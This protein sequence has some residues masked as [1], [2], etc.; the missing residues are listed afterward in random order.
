MP[1]LYLL[2]FYVLSGAYVISVCFFS[3]CVL[4]SNICHLYVFII[5]CV[6]V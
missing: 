5:L 3:S 1:S 4:E 2:S 6:E